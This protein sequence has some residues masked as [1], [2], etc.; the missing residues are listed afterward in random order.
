[1]T[2]REQNL[3]FQTIELL[4]KTAKSLPDFANASDW[5]DVDDWLFARLDWTAEDLDALYHGREALIYTGS[6]IPGFAPAGLTYEELM[7][8]V[9]VPCT[10]RELDL[11]WGKPIV[12]QAEI[13]GSPV[14]L[15]SGD[16]PEL[17]NHIGEGVKVIVTEQGIYLVSQSG[18]LLYSVEKRN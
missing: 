11:P 4:R 17:Q 18:A 3:V 15:R 9:G 13:P 6:T 10:C 1:M 14:L 8:F 2:K 5:K 12:V 7:P 16:C